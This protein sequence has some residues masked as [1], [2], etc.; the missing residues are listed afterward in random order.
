[1]TCMQWISE[2]AEEANQEVWL[3]GWMFRV[4]QFIN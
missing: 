1:M 2:K 4:A 3:D